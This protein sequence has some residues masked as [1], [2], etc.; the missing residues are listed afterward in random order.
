MAVGFAGLL[1]GCNQNYDLGKT[2]YGSDKV[3]IKVDSGA[4]ELFDRTLYM[5]RQNSE[6]VNTK[7]DLATLLIG[8]DADNDGKVTEEE[9]SGY[10]QCQREK[11]L[12]KNKAKDSC[13]K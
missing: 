5:R 7:E 12:N 6:P 2:P 9:L 1:T 10:F 3:T 4:K 8:L 13:L 11:L